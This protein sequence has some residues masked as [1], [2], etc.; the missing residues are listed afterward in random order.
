MKKTANES[1]L[2]QEKLG[3]T[4]E[5]PVPRDPGPGRTVSSDVYWS[6][7]ETLLGPLLCTL[8]AI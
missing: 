8:T 2:R 7:Q 1:A 4:F 5:D 3:P 6:V